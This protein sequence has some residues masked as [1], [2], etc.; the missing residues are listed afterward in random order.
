[1]PLTR[2]P[3]RDDQLI[4]H[5]LGS[6]PEDEAQR[7][8]EESIVDDEVAARLQVAE[9]DLVDS[10]ARGTLGGDRLARFESFY[11]ASLLRRD[12]VAF[13]KR[14]VAAID[15][16]SPAERET[17]TVAAGWRGVSAWFPWTLA[18]AAALLLATGLL[19]ARDVGLR[20]DMADA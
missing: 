12:K 3:L 6:L 1:M 13:A 2:E 10:Y 8:E 9:D 17:S 15:R 5:L 11:L 18:A 7:V 4:R 14:F 19:L 20:R 16:A